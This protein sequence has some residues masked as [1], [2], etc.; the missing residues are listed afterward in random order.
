MK[1]R[2]VYEIAWLLEV[3]STGSDVQEKNKGKGILIRLLLMGKRDWIGND[4]KDVLLSLSNLEP[5]KQTSVKNYNI[6]SDLRQK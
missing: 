6:G 4:R 1:D 5:I 3:L 2:A